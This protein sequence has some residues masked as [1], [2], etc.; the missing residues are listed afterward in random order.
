[1]PPD[2]MRHVDRAVADYRRDQAALSDQFAQP[3]TGDRETTA[4]R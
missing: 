4:A 2:L 1:M 3:S